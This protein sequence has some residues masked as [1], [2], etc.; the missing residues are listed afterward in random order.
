MWSQ[1]VKNGEIYCIHVVT[2]YVRRGAIN[3]R[4]D[5]E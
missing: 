2:E 4:I 3:E 5:G 1:V